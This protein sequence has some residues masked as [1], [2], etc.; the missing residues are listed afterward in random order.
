MESA[1]LLRE[2]VIGLKSPSRQSGSKEAGL[3]GY[4]IIQHSCNLKEDAWAYGRT[5]GYTSTTFRPMA[6]RLRSGQ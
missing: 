4:A 5:K 6:N 1:L 3:P 2:Q